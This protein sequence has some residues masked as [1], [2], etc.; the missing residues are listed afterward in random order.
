MIAHTVER[1]VGQI[2]ANAPIDA[3]WLKAQVIAAAG[4]I[5]EADQDR[6]LFLNPDDAALIADCPLGLPMETDASLARGDIRIEAGPG[7]VEAG[8]SV[9]LDALKTA[10]SAGIQSA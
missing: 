4:A 6:V 5:G 9:H 3:D 1:L 10:L 7:W 8:R 2:V